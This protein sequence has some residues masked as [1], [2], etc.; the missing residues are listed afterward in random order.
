MSPEAAQSSAAEIID[1]NAGGTDE[2]SK[3]SDVTAVDAQ[4][5][6]QL[7]GQ[8]GDEFD[9]NLDFPRQAVSRFADQSII[10]AL[11]ET[12]LGNDPRIVDMAAKVGRLLQNSSFNS[13]P[14]AEDTER[15]EL[16][17]ELEALAGSPDYWED[18]C[19]KRV[20]QI[21]I[22]LHIEDPVPLYEKGNTE[23]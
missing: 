5:A 2:F 8:W 6:D 10:E 13:V 11:E 21:H 16:I 12:G 19:Q 14:K 3:F 9:T 18:E 20:R 1:R 15:I 23:I 4:I 22:A 17:T 7:L